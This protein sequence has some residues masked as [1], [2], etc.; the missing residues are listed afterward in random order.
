MSVEKFD[1]N[2]LKKAETT[3]KSVLPS[4]SGDLSPVLI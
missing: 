2:T 4:A 3:E 1:K